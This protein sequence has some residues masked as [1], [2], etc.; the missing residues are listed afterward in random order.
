[1][2]KETKYMVMRQEKTAMKNKKVLY[3]IIA[4]CYWLVVL[5]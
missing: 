4:G 1:M 5:G 3:G 2:S